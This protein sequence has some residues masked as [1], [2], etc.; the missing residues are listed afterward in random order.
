MNLE[1]VE[2]L[3]LN[4]LGQVT[5]PVVPVEKLLAYCRREQPDLVVDGAAFLHFLRHHGEITVLEGPAG[6]EPVDA[7]EFAAAGI[8]MGPRAVLKTRIPAEDNMRRVMERQLEAMRGQLEAALAAA[9]K[10]GDREKTAQLR[11]ALKK[12]EELL[13]R[14]EMR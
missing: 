8:M 9:R 6:G 1:R 11:A 4:Y 5:N 12:S 2:E 14:L 10:A 13:K 7:D 3:C